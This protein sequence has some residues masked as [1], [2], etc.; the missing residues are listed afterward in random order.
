MVSLYRQLCRAV[1]FFL[2]KLNIPSV[3]I[4]LQ[5]IEHYYI[6]ELFAWREICNISFS[7]IL[8]KMYS[9]WAS[10]LL[11]AS[12]SIH[13]PMQY[14][15]ISLTATLCFCAASFPCLYRIF[16]VTLEKMVYLSNLS[17]V[18]VHLALIILNISRSIQFIDCNSSLFWLG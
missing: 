7:C 16:S 18:C 8:H 10:L 9:S 1:V 2:N 17:E 14:I 3:P 12:V 11:L 13:N 5:V 6:F 4:A 15:F